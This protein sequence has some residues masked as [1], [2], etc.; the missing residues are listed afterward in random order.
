MEV[1]AHGRRARGS[2]GDPR[3]SSA[4]AHGDIL[5]FVA[6]LVL[7]FL[8]FFLPQLRSLAIRYDR[9]ATGRSSCGTACELVVTPWRAGPCGMHGVRLSPTKTAKT[10]PQLNAFH[11]VAADAANLLPAPPITLSAGCI[12]VVHLVVNGQDRSL[13]LLVDRAHH[14]PKPKSAKTATRKARAALV[15]QAHVDVMKFRGLVWR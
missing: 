8:E 4:A 5:S 1:P 7:V 12:V 6:P 9:R 2:T 15:P 13:L 10:L 14:P 11:P 3:A